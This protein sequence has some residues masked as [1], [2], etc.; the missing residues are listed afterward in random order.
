MRV[1][2]N[3]DE[4]YISIDQE[5]AI[6]KLAKGLLSAEEMKT[7]SSVRY[8]MLHSKLLP[9]LPADSPDRVTDKRYF[10]MLSCCGSLLHIANSVRCDVASSVGILCRHAASYGEDF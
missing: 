10:H 7:A 6:S 9:R 3:L 5:L 2:Q 8:P 1:R 4:G